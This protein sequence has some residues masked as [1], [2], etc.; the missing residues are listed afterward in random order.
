MKAIKTLVALSVL[1]MAGATN[2]ATVA[3]FSADQVGT[4]TTATDSLSGTGSVDSSGQLTLN[5]SGDL[6][7]LLFPAGSNTVALTVTETLD[8]SLSGNTW[9]AA[10]TGNWQLNSCSDVGSATL[11]G[12]LGTLPLDNSMTNVSGSFDVTT[13]GVITSDVNFTTPA[14][15]TMNAT[16]TLSP[17]VS[18]VPLPA[19]A[20]LFGSG[21]LGLAGTARRRCAA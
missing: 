5:Y 3:T 16:D 1:A 17:T 4:S 12:Y 13:G 6:T 19:A 8:G 20:W 14:T 18:P 15:F 11:C 21:L 2:A 10:G 9:T 7:V